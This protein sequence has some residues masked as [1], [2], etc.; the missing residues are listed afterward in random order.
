[1]DTPFIDDFTKLFWGVGSNP[2]EPQA[3]GL[4][5][6]PGGPKGYKLVDI[7][8]FDCLIVTEP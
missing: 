1:M 5:P 8:V 4:R 7:D 3:V 2:T 6:S